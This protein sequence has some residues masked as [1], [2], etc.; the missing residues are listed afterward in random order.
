DGAFQPLVCAA[1]TR[2]DETVR[3]MDRLA[4]TASAAQRRKSRGQT[5][6]EGASDPGPAGKSDRAPGS[7]VRR[8]TEATAFAPRGSRTTRTGAGRDPDL[9]TRRYAAV[10]CDHTAHNPTTAAR[11]REIRSPKSEIGPP[12]SRFSS[13]GD[14]SAQRAASA[15]R[16]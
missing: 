8:E 3:S 10:G 5:R 11:C 15:K 14:R 12:P 16:V 1:D 13:P 9:H 2:H 4:R 6:A 7:R